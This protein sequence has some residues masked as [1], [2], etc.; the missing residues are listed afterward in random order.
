MLKVW[1]PM[2]LGAWALLLLGLLT[3]LSA[4][5]A[6]AEEKRIPWP[7]L[8]RLR[9]GVPGGA[10]TIAGALL[11]LFMAGYT[12]VL[13]SVTNRPIWADSPFVGVLFLVSGAST[14][15]ATLS[16]LGRSRAAPGTLHWLQRFDGRLLV[17]EIAVLA[18][19]L[20]SLGPVAQAWLNG[21]GAVL[22]L[23]VLGAGI[24]VPLA[25]HNRPRWF[26]ERISRRAIVTAA[27]LV[28]IGGL[29]LRVCVILAS[30]A[31]DRATLVAG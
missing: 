18:M 2:S 24:L 13:L 29:L 4:L 25:I 1:S 12:G 21:W 10:V 9:R 16:L 28:L 6:L 8:T 22:L 26:G 19:F 20:I 5:G 15:A 17:L 23:G 31:I 7:A 11:G 30:E 27:S 3:T 14:A